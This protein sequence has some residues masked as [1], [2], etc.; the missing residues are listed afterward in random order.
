PGIYRQNTD[1]RS[2]W[3]AAAVWW[4]DNQTQ[5]MRLSLG[6]RQ[7][8]LYRQRCPTRGAWLQ[9]G[10]QKVGHTGAHLHSC[11][12]CGRLEHGQ[13]GVLVEHGTY[14]RPHKDLKAHKSGPWRAWQTKDEGLSTAG[15]SGT[16]T[17]TGGD[18]TKQY[19]STAGRHSTR[20]K[21]VI[22]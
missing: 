8:V 1:T 13:A 2:G 3:Q 22:A 6:Q 16:P 9:A 10:G 5:G 12:E 19:L 4:H 7:Q 11:Y 17:R 21:I 14:H 18:P 20:G 15:H